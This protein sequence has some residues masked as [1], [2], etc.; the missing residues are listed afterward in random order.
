MPNTK[1][2]NKLKE[3]FGE[4]VK[5]YYSP[6]QNINLVYPCVVYTREPNEYRKANDKNYI[7]NIVWRVTLFD[8]KVDS[9][10][11]DKL[12]DH[13]DYCENVSRE[14]YDSILQSVYNIKF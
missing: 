9:E 4:D 11:P 5:L 6:T 3:I 10:L 8:T 13:F 1:L 7:K 12:E 14:F 2:R